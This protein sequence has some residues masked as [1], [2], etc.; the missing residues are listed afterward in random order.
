MTNL[1][2]SK[3][4]KTFVRIDFYA[5]S[6]QYKESVF[7]YVSTI[8]DLNALRKTIQEQLILSRSMST[9]EAQKDTFWAT[10][11]TGTDNKHAN[12]IFELRVKHNETVLPCNSISDFHLIFGMQ[13]LFPLVP[14]SDLDHSPVLV[15]CKME[16]VNQNDDA[17][18]AKQVK[19]VC[20]DAYD[21]VRYEP[22]I[23]LLS[24]IRQLLSESV[25]AFLPLKTR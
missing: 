6:Y 23:Q 12:E 4:N 17:F 22:S 20:D 16:K 21:L 25:C 1:I 13:I 24:D 2:A 10:F 19:I 14:S 15:K 7:S 11:S 9:P 5:G 3:E 18:A 8:A